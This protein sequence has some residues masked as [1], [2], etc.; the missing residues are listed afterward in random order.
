MTC[1]DRDFLWQKVKSWSKTLD[2]LSRDQTDY[3]P[4]AL[5][6]G[7]GKHAQER[8][9]YAVTAAITVLAVIAGFQ[10]FRAERQR[11]SAAQAFKSE[12]ELA[13]KLQ[14][15]LRQASWTS[16]SQAERQFQLES[17]GKVSLFWRVR[18]SLTQNQVA[19]QRFFQELIVH[20]G[21]GAAAAHRLFAHQ[22]AVVHVN[23]SPDA[24]S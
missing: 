8:I 21:E 16:F 11:Q 20:R 1:W 7:D 3:I 5:R 12:A 2:P 23:F 19:S 6:S 24:R 9:R 13:A 22:D 18:S 17:G 14:E 10:W 4:G 15:Q